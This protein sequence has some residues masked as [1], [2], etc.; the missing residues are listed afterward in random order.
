[1]LRSV[2]AKRVWD[3]RRGYVW[4]LAGLG[5]L[6]LLTA[7]FWPSLADSAETFQRML[8]SMPEGLLSLFGSSDSAQLLTPSGFLNSRL[9]ASIGAIVICLFAVSMGT[10]AIA[11]EEHDGTLDM[12][13]AQ[14][15]SR[16]RVVTDSF[17]A[18]TAMT[19]GLAV[20]VGVILAL[21][22]P[23]VDTGLSLA[24]IAGAT[25]GVTILGLVFGTLALMLGGF[26]LRRAT[27]TGVASGLVLGT[28]FVNGLAPLVSELA[29]LQKL[30]PF[31]WFL[32]TKP[33]D[34]GLGPELL[35]LVFVVF[36]QLAV[37]VWAFD[38]R[39]VAV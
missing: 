15:V 34:A 3:R 5:A 30:T 9:Y 28:W 12:L 20:G 17:W 26:G 31:F 37:A 24:N 21:I 22:N 29:W 33:L 4:W 7:G 27:V 13:L 32:E 25:I 10:A 38:R 35:L 23:V 2:F 11:G 19:L 18:M 1:M 8:D 36:A 16:I 6:T 39:D 14:P